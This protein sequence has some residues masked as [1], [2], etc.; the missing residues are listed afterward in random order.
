MKLT[1]SLLISLL[2]LASLTC[3]SLVRGLDVSMA[4]ASIVLAYTGSR[5]G[6]KGTGMLAASRDSAANTLEAIDKLK[7]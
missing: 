2:G 7:D 5:A 6:L 3:I 4:V 1:N